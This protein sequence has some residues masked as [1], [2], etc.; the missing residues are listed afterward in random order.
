MTVPTAISRVDSPCNGSSTVFPFSFPVAQATDLRVILTDSNGNKRVLVLNSDYSVNITGATGSVTTTQTYASG[1]TLTIKRLLTITQPTSIRNQG[2]FFPEIHEAVFDRLTEIDQQQDEQLSRCFMIDETSSVNPVLPTPTPLGLLRWNS[3]GTGLENVLSGPAYASTTVS[4]SSYGSD[5]SAAVTA[6]GSA[7]VT[8]VVDSPITVNN[9]TTVNPNTSLKVQKPGLLTI[10]SGKV[11]TINGSLEAPP[12]RQIFAGTGTVVGLKVAYP[13]WWGENTTPGTTD[14]TAAINAASASVITAL[15]N[16]DGTLLY[17]G[18][19]Q[20]QVGTYRH[21]TTLIYTGAPWR[22]A[23]VLSTILDYYGSA[24]GVNALGAS[25]IRKGL[26][27]HEL[28]IYGGHATGSANGLQLGWN[29]RSM[30]ALDNVRID[31]YPNAGIYFA[32]DIWIADFRS[33]NI[34]NCGVCAMNQDVACLN[35]FQ[36]VWFNTN[37]ENNGNGTTHCIR[38]PNNGSCQNW[39]MYGGD[40]ESNNCLSSIYMKGGIQEFHDIYFEELLP[41]CFIMDGNYFAIDNCYFLPGTGTVSQIRALGLSYGTVRD[42]TFYPVAYWVTAHSY[43]VGDWIQVNYLGYTTTYKCAVAHTSAAA[44][45]TDFLAGKWTLMDASGLSVEA[46]SRV[47]ISG[48]NNMVSKLVP[49]GAHYPLISSGTTQVVDGWGVENLTASTNVAMIRGNGA[50]SWQNIFIAPRSG[51]VTGI[52]LKSN[53]P[54]TAG[55][56]TATL[57]VNGVSKSGIQAILDGTNTTICAHRYPPEG[58]VWIDAGDEIK[59]GIIT[60]SAWLPATADVT[61]SL[62]MLF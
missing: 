12:L 1:Y 41:S 22:G 44:F 51:L 18:Y 34:T 9:N 17:T 40:F 11:L 59:I 6:I 54:R 61:A 23:G 39:V 4:A 13:E 27:I 37:V 31:K 42:N 26:S 7:N 15:Q 21:N 14:M 36:M 60:D 32:G 25:G 47:T 38:I 58:G 24:I 29:Q 43:L 16:S 2:A 56:A 55:T 45:S 52:I 57:I 49:G 48:N 30:R 19:V 10:A 28:T 20:F 8:L 3:T 35:L 5:L 46:D 33:V 53:T 50:A 62:E